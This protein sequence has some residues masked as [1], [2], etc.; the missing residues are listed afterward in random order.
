MMAVEI[1]L[2]LPDVNGEASAPGFEGEIEIRSFA[3]GLSN[4]GAVGRGGGG[5]AG[6]AVFQDISFV[7]PLSKAGPKLF[8]A[9]ATGKQIPS[10]ELSVR[11]SGERSETYYIIKLG[12]VFLSSYQQS[13]AEGDDGLTDEFSL[14]YSRIELEYFPQKQDGT[15]DSSVKAGYDVKGNKKI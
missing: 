13:G 7:T 11:R 10:A 2:K 14:V 6:K 15:L 8:E 1:F 9:C 4:S 12:D 3:W 5:G